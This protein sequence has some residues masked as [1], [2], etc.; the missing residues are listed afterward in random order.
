M[1]GR[2][3][4]RPTDT[5]APAFALSRG[6]TSGRS[7]TRPRSSGVVSA[8]IANPTLRSSSSTEI[9]PARQCARSCACSALRSESDARV[10]PSRPHPNDPSSTMT[11][12]RASRPAGSSDVGAEHHGRPPRGL[13]A[14]HAA[15]DARGDRR[16][17]RA[18]KAVSRVREDHGNGHR[19]VV[20]GGEADERHHGPVAVRAASAHG[21]GLPGDL[22]AAQ[23][24][25]GAGAVGDH[26]PQHV[27]EFLGR[28]RGHRLGRTS[29]CAAAPSSSFN[30][31][32]GLGW[33]SVGPSLIG[34]TSQHQ[35]I[36]AARAGCIVAR[37]C[38]APSTDPGVARRGPD[39]AA[40]GAATASASPRVCVYAQERN[41][42]SGAYTGHA[43]V[44]LLPDAGPQ[45]RAA[46]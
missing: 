22:Q 46:T 28:G 20:G 11:I 34:R 41:I 33:P 23:T 43:F 44:Q 2:T 24:G 45:G 36:R 27:G 5:D 1:N 37:R 3:P 35:A 17:L 10:I 18:A 4:G 31:A 12:T 13:P 16:C 7:A 32:R 9:L 39:L 21:R 30:A 6:R 38:E 8:R 19:R 15:D 29:L 42:L 25:G 14:Q 26:T 40:A